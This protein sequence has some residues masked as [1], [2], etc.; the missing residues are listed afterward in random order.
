MTKPRLIFR[1]YSKSHDYLI[2]FIVQVSQK[3]IEYEGDTYLIKT[4]QSKKVGNVWRLDLLADPGKP[5]LSAFAGRGP[6]DMRMFQVYE[7]VEPS[8]RKA[9]GNPVLTVHW[10]EAFHTTN[11][12]DIDGQPVNISTAYP[13]LN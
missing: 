12:T 1:K 2:K 7:F 8:L 13:N 9:L 5:H 11:D 10:G 3:L 6:G 4:F